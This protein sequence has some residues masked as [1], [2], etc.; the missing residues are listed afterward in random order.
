MTLLLKLKRYLDDNNMKI[1]IHS[2]Y[3][4]NLARDWDEHSWWIKNIELEIK[5]A[6][7]LG[8]IGLVI[9][10]GKSLDIPLSQAYNNMYT[11]LVYLH[12]VTKEYKD[13]K[14]FL[15]T[16]TGQGTEMCYKLEDLAHFYRK[17]SSNVN[18]ELKDRIKL[19]I[20]TAHILGGFSGECDL[21]DITEKYLE[22]TAEIH[23]QDYYEKGLVDH[24][25]LGTG[26]NFPS[27]FLKLLH[28][29]NFAGPIVF[30]LPRS[31]ALKSIEYIK[32]FVPQ[33]DLPNIKNQP[34]Y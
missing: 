26:K 33:I 25:A 20:D 3:T 1:V 8:A 27:A 29:R 14:I 19:C 17:F 31:E 34:F 30:E 9:H 5:Y 21:V 10:F 2:S 7:M 11:S 13:V 4:H 16:S 6:H 18:S 32:K 28:K 22:I 15:E 12:N 23:L 24:G